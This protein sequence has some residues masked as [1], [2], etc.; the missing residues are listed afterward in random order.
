ML[1]TLMAVSIDRTAASV[2]PGSFPDRIVEAAATI[3]DRGLQ[4]D[5][6]VNEIA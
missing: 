5:Y 6:T 4:A 1:D 3:L 2:R